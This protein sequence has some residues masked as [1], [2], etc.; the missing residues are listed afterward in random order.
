MKE[1]LKIL[2]SGAE[3][4]ADNVHR[5]SL[6]RTWDY[7]KP[8]IMF[9]GL[10]PSRA[11]A[12]KTDPTIT[13]CINFANQ[14]NFGSLFFANL[15]SFR[16]PY[17]SGPIPEKKLAEDEDWQLL[18]ENLHRTHTDVTDEHLQKMISKS[19]TIVCCW[20]SWKIPGFILRT[21]EVVGMIQKPYCFGTNTDGQPKHP[22]YLKSDCELKNFSL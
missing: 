7:N 6:W 11:N 18:I 22:L 16:T 4:S 15:F 21:K 19:A 2:D 10:N 3:L 12:V 13:R 1:K 17:V 5:Y 20:G 14:W 8:R 9:I